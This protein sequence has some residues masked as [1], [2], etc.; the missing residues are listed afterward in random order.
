[1]DHRKFQK[2]IL[3]CVDV[4]LHDRFIALGKH[5]PGAELPFTVKFRKYQER[6]PCGWLVLYNLPDNPGQMRETSEGLDL[7]DPFCS[8]FRPSLRTGRCAETGVSHEETCACC[9]S[10]D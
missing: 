3:A 5:F 8:Y 2:G 9:R 7:F 1:M 6:L 10:M 4:G